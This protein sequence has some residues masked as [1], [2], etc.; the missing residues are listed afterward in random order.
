MV[1]RVLT[2][3]TALQPTY[4]FSNSRFELAQSMTPEEQRQFFETDFRNILNLMLEK[5]AS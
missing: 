1:S 4:L 5:L 3:E 2:R